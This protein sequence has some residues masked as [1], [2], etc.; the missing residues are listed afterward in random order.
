[1]NGNYRFMVMPLY[2][3]N[4]LAENGVNVKD[5]LDNLTVAL[6][7]DDSYKPN[8]G[9]RKTIED[10]SSRFANVIGSAELHDM[11]AYN[12]FAPAALQPFLYDYGLSALTDVV[13]YNTNMF[14]KEI[15]KYLSTS[16]EVNFEDTYDIYLGQHTGVIVL[17][18]GFNYLVGNEV[19]FTETLINM[20]ESE[21]GAEV[22]YNDWNISCGY[23][24]LINK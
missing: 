5:D 24:S 9:P 12:H 19:A 10:I 11:F 4:V 8:S 18:D 6:N 21:K 7:S 1:M 17:K 13:R 22:I 23:L 14:N 20:I 16:K 2:M 15:Y 3:F